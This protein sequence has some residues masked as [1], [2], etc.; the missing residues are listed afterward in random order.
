MYEFLVDYVV[1]LV[2]LSILCLIGFFYIFLG[3]LCLIGFSYVF[4]ESKLFNGILN[5]KSEIA[6]SSF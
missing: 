4:L 5:G 6:R 1:M 2:D 3:I